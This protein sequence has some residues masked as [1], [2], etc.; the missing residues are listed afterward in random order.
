MGQKSEG[1]TNIK[2][3]E[4]AVQARR[5]IVGVMVLFAVAPFALAWI[6]GSL[7]F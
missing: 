1:E 2:A 5:I 6:S 7:C 4:K 3:C